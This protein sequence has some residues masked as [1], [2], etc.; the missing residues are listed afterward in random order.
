MTIRQEA[1]Q[2][3]DSLPDVSVGFVV[4]IIRNM[5]P[6]FYHGTVAVES[7]NSGKDE[8]KKKLR[9]IALLKDD[10]NG[11]GAEAF[12]SAHIGLIDNL[13]DGLV[14]APEIFPT[15]CDTIQ[16]EFDKLNGEHMEIE[17]PE[18]GPSEYFFIDTDGREHT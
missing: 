3:I 18:H 15:A 5:S 1:Y 13:L 17:V 8:S 9:Q 4:Q 2:L 6:E 14:Y 11:N 12:S 16:F 10:W 7:V